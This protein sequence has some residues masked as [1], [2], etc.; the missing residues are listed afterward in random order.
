MPANYVPDDSK[1]ENFIR[2]KYDLKRWVMPGPKPDPS[3]L[4][5]EPDKPEEALVSTCECERSKVKLGAQKFDSCW[6]RYWPL[7]FVILF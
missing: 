4:K 1:M 6:P 2:T 3:T 5:D 7:T